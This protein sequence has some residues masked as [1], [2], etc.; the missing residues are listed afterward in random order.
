MAHVQTV[1]GP[2]APDEVGRILHH[3]HLLSLTPGPWLS[4]GRSG[5]CGCSDE[6]RFDPQDTTHSNDQV[7][8]AVEALGGVAELGIRTIVDLSPYGVVGRDALGDNVVLLQ[9]IARR[10][11]L[12]IVSG[13]SV[14]LQ[15]FS[16]AWAVQADLSEMTARFIADA[17][18]GIGSTS[19]TAGIFGEQATGLGVI[20]P[21]EEKCLRAASRAHRETGLAMTTH[22]THGTMALEQVEIL[23]EEG[24][25]L[26]RVLIGHMD[27]HPDT[28][29]VRQV[30][31]T[32]VNIAFDTIG[33]QF[34]DFRVEPLP[35]EMPDGEFIK[36]A[37]FR[38]DRTRAQRIAQ[39]VSEGYE[40]HI[41]LAQDL[42]GSEVYLNPATHGQWGYTYLA[43]PFA[44]LLREHGVTEG[45][46][47]K[48]LHANPGRL[49]TIG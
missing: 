27:T 9:E 28:D 48:M 25:D 41:F 38:S 1:L 24:A 44:D 11:G 40:D 21:H 12:N 5:C 23:K 29:Y 14:Y 39:L 47:E 45:Q 17:T 2:V 3:E 16:P 26:R 8:R 43:S 4:G 36:N 42:T 15:E 19:V 49:L 18:A 10:T 20:T 35:S 31:D 37:Y 33:K 34:W 13:S 6:T 22:T 30:V 46:L 7:Q 32:G